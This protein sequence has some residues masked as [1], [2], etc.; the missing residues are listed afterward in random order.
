MGQEAYVGL[1]RDMLAACERITRFTVG[2]TFQE[3][4]ENEMAAYAVMKAF[5]IMGEAGRGIPTLE[6]Q[7]HAE[8]PWQK[9]IGMRD[10]LIHGYAG[11]D[12]EVVWSTIQED[13]PA[14]KPLLAKAIA[15]ATG[16]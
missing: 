6:R 10:R 3:F 16:K 2:M 7:R 13:V 8:I 4:C 12:L 1:L 11:V 5:E 14:L 15:G 9:I